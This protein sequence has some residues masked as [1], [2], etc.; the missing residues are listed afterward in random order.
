[1][2]PSGPGR[3]S[4]MKKL[5]VSLFS[6]LRLLLGILVISAVPPHRPYLERTFPNALSEVQ[7]V[8]DDL[9][10]RPAAVCRF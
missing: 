8:V 5:Y 7:R 9:I 4:A 1:M 6:V 3:A 2:A 10:L